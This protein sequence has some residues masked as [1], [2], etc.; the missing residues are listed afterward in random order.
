MGKF[1]L[2][3]KTNKETGILYTILVTLRQQV[4]WEG[5][6]AYG[7]CSRHGSDNWDVK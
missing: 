3:F 5:A 7:M 6:S 4:L 1:L 2:N